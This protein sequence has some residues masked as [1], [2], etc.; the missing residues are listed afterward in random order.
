MN[1]HAFL[2]YGHLTL[3]GELARIPPEAWSRPGVCGVWSVQDIVAH[4][5]S[6]EQAGID[7][8][9]TLAAGKAEAVATPTLDAYRQDPAGFNDAQV[10]ERRVY[11]AEHILDEYR[12]AHV[13]MLELAATLPHA[14]FSEIG[15]LPWYGPEYSPGDLVVYMYYGHKREHSAQIAMYADLLPGRVV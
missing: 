8:L 6:Y 7:I 2:K 10:E 13:Q 15:A 5:A 1:P 9:R 14:K 4:L 11:D 3:E 12:T